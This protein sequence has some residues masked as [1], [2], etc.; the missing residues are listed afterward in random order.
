[1]QFGELLGDHLHP[2]ML[3][4]YPYVNGVF[5]QDNYTSHKSRLAIGW[6]HVHYSDFSVINWPPRSPD[7]NPIEPLWDVLEQGGKDHHTAPKNLTELWK[8]LANIWQIIPV[9]PFSKLLNL[10]RRVEAVIKARG[11]LTRY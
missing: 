3:F 10:T 7:L 1:M 9:E 11:G 4:C 8:A 2:F 6:L 5:Q